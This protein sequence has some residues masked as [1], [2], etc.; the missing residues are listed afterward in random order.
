MH[1]RC[2]YQDICNLLSE[3]HIQYICVSHIQKCICIFIEVECLK[4][5]KIANNLIKN[6]KTYRL[7]KCFVN[8]AGNGKWPNF[9]KFIHGL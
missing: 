5:K 2:I 1:A 4:L 6:E 3:F 7:T 8:A 9:C